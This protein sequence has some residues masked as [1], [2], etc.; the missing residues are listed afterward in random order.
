MSLSQFWLLILATESEPERTHEAGNG[1]LH[2]GCEGAES[3]KLGTT[4]ESGHLAQCLLL[5]PSLLPGVKW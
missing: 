5:P 1:P 3:G 4:S 2:E